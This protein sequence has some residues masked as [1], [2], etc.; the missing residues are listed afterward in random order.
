M[1]NTSIL[2]N[3]FANPECVDNSLLELLLPLIHS[4]NAS[5]LDISNFLTM[6]DILKHSGK[7][8]EYIVDFITNHKFKTD[9]VAED[10]FVFELNNA[11]LIS[12]LPALLLLSFAG[13]KV[14]VS[15]KNSNLFN[16]AQILQID[17]VKDNKKLLSTLEKYN[18][19]LINDKSLF[20]NKTFTEVMHQTNFGSKYNLLNLISVPYNIRFLFL[21][22][23][24]FNI[25]KEFKQIK[26]TIICTLDSERNSFVQNTSCINQEII[27]TQDFKNVYKTIISELDN[28]NTKTFESLSW[29]VKTSQNILKYT[30]NLSYDESNK[31]I[32][33][34]LQKDNFSNFLQKMRENLIIGT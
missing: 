33:E 1:K 7:N 25:P 26:E 23:S 18:F 27:K 22:F 24:V 31:I 20:I 3:R 17:T 28:I 30:Y 10:I 19:A 2:V 9:L 4:K 21:D 6:L 11:N 12:F 14:L 5:P 8:Y 32:K 34:K 13:Y 15:T 29:I 16:F